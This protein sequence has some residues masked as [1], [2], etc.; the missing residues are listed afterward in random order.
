[1][2]ILYLFLIFVYFHLKLF[3]LINLFFEDFQVLF[4]FFIHYIHSKFLYY[5]FFSFVDPFWD[6]LYSSFDMFTF[7]S[8][9][10]TRV[11]KSTIISSISWSSVTRFRVYSKFLNL[12]I[13]A[14]DG[15]M[16]FNISRE[17]NWD[18]LFRI[19]SIN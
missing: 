6:N 5:L 8:F 3:I 13:L 19:K 2:Y 1:M 17:K 9:Y 15:Y 16:F 14:N 10:W 4:E 11:T 12:S 18:P 7:S